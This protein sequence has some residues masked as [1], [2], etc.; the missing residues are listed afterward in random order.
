MAKVIA[1][2]W[3]AKFV[4]FPAVL[5]VLPRSIWKK[6]LNLLQKTDFDTKQL[7]I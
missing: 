3:G 6:L 4:K 5:A 7:K 2:A 1:S